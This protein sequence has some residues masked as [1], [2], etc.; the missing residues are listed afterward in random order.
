MSDAI[1]ITIETDE[2]FAALDA[3]V[4]TIG[5]RTKEACKVT[6]DRVDAE[7]TGRVARRTGATAEGIFVE[8]TYDKTGYV[9]IAT[10]RHTPGLPG[11]LEYGTVKM[12]KRP[13][14]FASAH[15]EIGPH[16]RRIS[17]ATQ[18]AIDDVGLGP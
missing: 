16:G 15:L 17:E 3:V 4:E 7:A 18:D 13:F 6:A 1:T 8:E 5:D 10:N 2:L 12:T 11:F 9:V 14:L